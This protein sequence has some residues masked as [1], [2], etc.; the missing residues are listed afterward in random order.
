MVLGVQWFYRSACEARDPAVLNCFPFW[1]A[2]HL[3]SVFCWT[4]TFTAPGPC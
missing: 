1:L 3:T 2:I 4:L